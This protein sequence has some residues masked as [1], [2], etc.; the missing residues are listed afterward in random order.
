MTTEEAEIFAFL[1]RF[2]NQFLSVGDISKSVGS[3]KQFNEDRN[4][5]LPTLRRMTLEGWIEV[6]PIGDFRAAHQSDETTSF[7]KALETPGAPL[8]DTAII[9]ISDVQDERSKA[10]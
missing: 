10:A 2:P 5:A 9:C 7:K 6:S 8:G 3:R 4:W 1:K